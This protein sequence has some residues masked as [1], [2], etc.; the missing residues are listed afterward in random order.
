MSSISY[1][2]FPLTCKDCSKN[3]SPWAGFNYETWN[4]L[5]MFHVVGNSSWYATG[6][7]Y[8]NMI[9]GPA[10]KADSFL[11]I[12]LSGKYFVANH[13]FWPI[14]KSWGRRWRSALTFICS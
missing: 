6:P 1:S 7:I 10:H 12:Y 2:S 3:T 5:C 11:V 13:T 14:S 9:N 8:F 4:T